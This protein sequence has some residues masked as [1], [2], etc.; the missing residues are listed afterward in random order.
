[1]DDHFKHPASEKK[2]KFKRNVTADKKE[3]ALWIGIITVLS[4]ILSAVLSLVSA[5]LLKGID[6][7]IAF[8][9]LLLIICINIIADIVGTSA[10][11]ADEAP[12]HAMAS[13]KLFGARQSIRL[14]RNAD[15]VSNLC[16]DVIGDICGVISGAASAYIV[17]RLIGRGSEVSVL[18]LVLTGLV[19]SL[20]VGGKALGKIIAIKNSNLII[21]RVGVIIHFIVGKIN[22]GK[23]FN[24]KNKGKK[25]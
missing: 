15:K 14:I 20:T 12:F 11:A 7:I 4:F 9:L 1:M 2:V 19:A 24:P 23:I 25:K 22:I 6:I 3:N 10:T 18:E 13:R 5:N 17:I 8:F 16:N 21:Y